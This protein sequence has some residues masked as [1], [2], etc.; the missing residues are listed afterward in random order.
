MH[1]CACLQ[2]TSSGGFK[3]KLVGVMWSEDPADE[4]MR[5]MG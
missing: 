1:A 3:A 4:S 2:S 5:H